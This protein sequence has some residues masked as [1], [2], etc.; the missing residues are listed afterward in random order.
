[1]M[2]SVSPTLGPFA[3]ALGPKLI[4]LIGVVWILCL[5]GAVV[6]VMKGGLEFAASR[7]GGRPMATAD[8][9]MDIG[10]PVMALIFLGIIPAVVQALL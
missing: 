1:M 3:E 4:M 7:S 5:V 2:Q 9:V 10:V 6:L 8:G